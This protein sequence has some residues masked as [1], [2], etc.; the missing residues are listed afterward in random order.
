MG[1]QMQL[2]SPKDEDTAGMWVG[3]QQSLPQTKFPAQFQSPRLNRHES[4][5]TTL[6]D[7]AVF[8]DRPN[9]S[10]PTVFPLN[11]SDP[12]GM[13]SCLVRF[14]RWYA[15]LSPEIPPPTITM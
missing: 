1:Q 6:N 15:A 9:F 4:V 12:Q 2:A 7:E 3:G 11:Q 10:A 8:P 14:I 13:P 5:R